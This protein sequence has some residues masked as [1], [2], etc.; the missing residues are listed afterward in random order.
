MK[1]FLLLLLLPALMLAGCVKTSEPDS[2]A[3]GTIAIVPGDLSLDCEA[4]ITSAEQSLTVA[5]KKGSGNPDFFATWTI[6][7]NETWLKF[8]LNSDGSEA[9]TEIDGTGPLTIYLVV[10]ENE[11][12][13]PRTAEIFLNGAVAGTVTQAEMLPGTITVTPGSV[14]LDGEAH[15]PALSNLTVTC[16]KY[17]GTSSSAPWTL[18]SNQSWLKLSL[19]ANGS[20]AAATLNGTGTR[21]VY[22]VV[23]TNIT[24]ASRSA[25]ITLNSGAT[26]EVTVTQ[27]FKVI[28]PALPV[29]D[30]SAMAGITFGGDLPSAARS[31]VG[32]F[33]RASQTGERV[34]RNYVD[35][36]ANAGAW[37]ATVA[38][39]DGQWNPADGDGVVLALGD[40]PDP[41]IRKATPGDAESY[42]VEGLA[43]TVSGTV[44]AGE[45]ITFRAGLTK[46][47]SAYNALSKPTRYAVIVLNFGNPVKK[48]KIFLR[49]GEGADYLMRPGDKDGSG[50]DF[51]DSRTFARRFS[52]Y[53]LTA[54]DAQWA[55]SPGNASSIT[56]HPQL[57]VNGGTFVQYPSIGGAI[58]QGQ[59]VNGTAAQ[60]RAYNPV[61]F[62]AITDWVTPYAGPALW[63]S[64]TDETCPP[65]YRRPRD[66]DPATHGIATPNT[67]V[68]G[69][70]TR[71]S[72]WLVPKTG[73]NDS[74]FATVNSIWGYYAD[75]YFDRREITN[76]ASPS[77]GTLGAVSATTYNAAYRGRLFINPVSHNSLFI[78]APG[79][80]TTTTLSF[81]GERAYYWTCSSF[82][83]T[84]MGCIYLTAGIGSPYSQSRAFGWSI[85]CILNP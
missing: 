83:A 16:T 29:P 32:A 69:S 78:P 33:W 23:E 1:R 68:E 63:N 5:C 17:N 28:L 54:S 49:Q 30:G 37:S 40:S 62:E 46:T 71:Q 4:Q 2:S 48:Q 67:P 13:N 43:A 59:A 35:G 8:S 19:N 85:R 60:R 9:V 44:A 65:G 38:W 55:V 73:L 22:L 15:N 34:I 84:N 24:T 66:S 58:F 39:Y 57:D 81:A 25:G 52:P 76:G 61:V 79:Y 14:S 7:L 82:T 53:N 36:A 3:P 77:P 75:G 31:Y 11:D 21:S 80:R 10:E 50:A 26:P 70:E 72:L 51:P 56:T 6:S 18:A 27:D 12:S 20:D 42:K 74:G 64:A 47:F 45:F 41:N